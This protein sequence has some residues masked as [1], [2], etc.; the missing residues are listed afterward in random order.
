MSY[1]HDCVNRVLLSYTYCVS[2]ILEPD[3]HTNAV[4]EIGN[5][6]LNTVRTP[7][8]ANS[9]SSNLNSWGCLKELSPKDNDCYDMS[10][11]ASSYLGI[12]AGCS[13]WGDNLVGLLPA[14]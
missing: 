4:T 8:S 7:I 6:A 9:T 11:A 13:W 10:N 1:D 5:P 3:Y 12:I 2:I 14:E